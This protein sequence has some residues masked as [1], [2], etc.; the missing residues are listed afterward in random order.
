MRGSH[1]VDTEQHIWIRRAISE[2]AVDA[3]K[4]SRRQPDESGD[5][6][7]SR[8]CQFL[9]RSSYPSHRKPPPLRGLC[10]E[11]SMSEKDV[12]A[13]VFQASCPW[14]R[15]RN[16]VLKDLALHIAERPEDQVRKIYV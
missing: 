2:S 1:H 5:S 8:M 16:V 12:I 4:L 14:I 3:L 9:C 7:V 13:L 10:G 15:R 6:T 11:Q